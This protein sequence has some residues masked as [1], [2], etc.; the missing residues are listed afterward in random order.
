VEKKVGLKQVLTFLFSSL[1]IMTNIKGK[2]LHWAG[3]II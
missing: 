3:K 2:N 1:S